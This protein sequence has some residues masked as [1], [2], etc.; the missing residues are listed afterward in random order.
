MQ[1]TRTTSMNAKKEKQQQIPPR[2][3][4]KRKIYNNNKIVQEIS[5]KWRFDFYTNSFKLFFFPQSGTAIKNKKNYAEE[6]KKK[7]K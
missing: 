5:N 4:K 7:E 3:K 6:G 2:K 1:T